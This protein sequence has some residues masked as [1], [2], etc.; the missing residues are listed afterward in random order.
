MKLTEITEVTEPNIFGI[1]GLGK[2]IIQIEKTK[3]KNEKYFL[4]FI[5]D[6]S[7]EHIRHLINGN[8]ENRSWF[9]VSE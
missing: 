8:Q 9:S 1:L 4:R 6:Y 2:D 3:N 7:V 5:N